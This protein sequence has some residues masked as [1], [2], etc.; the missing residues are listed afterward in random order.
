MH[1]CKDYSLCADA[2]VVGRYSVYVYGELGQF[3]LKFNYIVLR[4][5]VIIIDELTSRYFPLN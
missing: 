5:E 2:A 4:V 1:T 3:R